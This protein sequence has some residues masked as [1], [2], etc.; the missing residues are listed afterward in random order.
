LNLK[1]F[2]SLTSEKFST[3]LLSSKALSSG[4]HWFLFLTMPIV[5]FC[6]GLR[7]GSSP[8]FATLI[9]QILRGR[10]KL[11]R[12]A[13]TF[14]FLHRKFKPYRMLD[15]LYIWDLLHITQ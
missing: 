1:L 7:F 6:S 4:R 5:W 14:H 12:H 9:G 8:F 10:Q 15:I 11:R 13:Q 3:A 2:Q